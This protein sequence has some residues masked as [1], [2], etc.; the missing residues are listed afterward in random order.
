MFPA[1]SNLMKTTPGPNQV[2]EKNI[3]FFYQ[4]LL[5]FEQTN[6]E[7]DIYQGTNGS[8]VFYDWLTRILELRN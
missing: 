4:T 7:V 2:P 1:L 5:T 8:K 3:S 6:R